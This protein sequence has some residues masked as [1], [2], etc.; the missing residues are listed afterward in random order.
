[1]IVSFKRTGARRYA[2]VIG[3]VGS[4]ERVM[5]PAPGYDDDIPHDLVHYVVE[6]ELG[7]TRGVFG[8]A[9]EGGGT[10]VAREAE[11]LSTRE[12]A[13]QRR[14]QQ[15]REGSLRALDESS[16]HEMAASEQLAGLCD[17]AWRRKHGQRPDA[18]RKPPEMTSACAPSDIERVVAQLDALAPQ[19]RGLPVGGALPFEWPSV[20]APTRL[21]RGYRSSCS[22]RGSARR[23]R[24]SLRRGFRAGRALQSLGE[25]GGSDGVADATWISRLEQ[26]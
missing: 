13:R 14:K 23:A 11:G 3:V 26:R 21:P 17:V 7:F 8:R 10:F 2:V 18:L 19:W 24:V 22:A 25:R 5:D 15:K 6:A 16:A 4:P 20:H 12:R 9:A 1:M